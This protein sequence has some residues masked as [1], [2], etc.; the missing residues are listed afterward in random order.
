MF[1]LIV[2][3]ALV[4]GFSAG[5]ILVRRFFVSRP[6]PVAVHQL[7]EP[8]ARFWSDFTAGREVIIAF[9]SGT[10]LI[11]ESGDLLRFRRGNPVGER[12]EPVQRDD[13]HIAALNSTLAFH[14][15]PLFYEDGFTGT[16]EVLAAYRLA[17]TLTALGA[18]VQVKRSRLVTINDLQTHDIIFLGSPFGNQVLGEMHLQQRFTFRLPPA[19]PQLWRGEIVDTQSPSKP[20]YGTERDPQ[21]QVIRADY[22]LFDVLP[23]PVHGRRIA[24]L[25]GLG[26]SGTDGAAEFATSPDG[27]R[28]ILALPGAP[29]DKTGSPA[30]P[31]YF[32][33]LLRVEAA[34]GLEAISTKFVDGNVVHPVVPQN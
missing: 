28:Q 3:F 34:K 13:A 24:V 16:G 9:T 19:G 12:G 18:S 5:T 20:A 27:L 25:A 21:N 33:C 7:P 8:V 6:A 32:E 31:P 14:A 11:T 1:F 23:G 26:T 2:V 10:Y 22:A 17:S 15:G 30:F 4:V 29:R